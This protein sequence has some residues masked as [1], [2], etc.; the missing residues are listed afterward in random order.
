[1]RN[2]DL[3]ARNFFAPSRDTLKRN[4]FGG[5]IGGPVIKNKLFFFFGYQD[6]ITRQ[7]PVGEHGRDVCPDRRDDRQAISVPARRISALRC[8]PASPAAISSQIHNNVIPAS[9]FDPA[10]LK[11]AATAA[12][13]HGP[14][15]NTGYRP[16]YPTSTRISMSAAAI[17]KPARRIRCS[18]AIFALTTSGRRRYNF[19]PTNLLTTTQ[20]ALNDADQ[21]WVVGRHVFVQPHSGESVPRFRGPDRRSSL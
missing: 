18:A 7:D 11:L 3:N 17:T 6:T 12:G 1:M 9:L 14:C 13:H 8:W 15:G 21:S 4:Q 19:T 10:A 5:T 16:G 20:G 2:G